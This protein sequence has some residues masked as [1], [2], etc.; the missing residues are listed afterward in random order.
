ML[1]TKNSKAGFFRLTALLLCMTLLMCG[2]QNSGSAVSSAE[3]LPAGQNIGEETYKTTE[4]YTGDFVVTFETTT[5]LTA[6]RITEM[7]W[8]FSG[9][10]YVSINVKQGDYVSA[11]DVL[12]EISP[13]VSEADRLQKQLA[14]TQASTNASTT[15]TSYEQ[16]I[17]QKEAT[18]GSLSGYDYEIALKEIELLRQQLNEKNTRIW[19]GTVSANKALADMDEHEKATELL[20]PY[21]GYVAGVIWGWKEGDTVPT[22]EPLILLADVSTLAI[23][24]TNNSAYG[25][26]PYLSTVTLTDQKDQSVYNGTVISGAAV[27]G[28]ATDDLVIIPEI[29]ENKIGTALMGSIKVKG[30]IMDKEDVVLVSSDA[31][32]KDGETYFV[33]V[34]Q[35]DQTISKTYVSIGGISGG[36]AWV[37]EGIDSGETLVLN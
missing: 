5:K 1:V 17:Q 13:T 32:N 29:P 4:S 18:L 30:T 2:C 12:A 22:N 35:E 26:V 34:L 15:A 11:G 3:Y 23:R 19:H 27:T 20:A 16:M 14:L 21:D 37:T 24:C 25:Y 8:P 33:L 10:K 28:A 9:D 36:I 7:Y 6:L 31:L